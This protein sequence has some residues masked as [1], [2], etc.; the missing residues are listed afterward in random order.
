[1]R[2]EDFPSGWTEAGDEGDRTRCE[3]V[4]EA[5][6]A[7]TARVTSPRFR[8]GENTDV[9]N[10]IYVF[11]DEGAAEQALTQLAAEDTRACYAK[12]VTDA[13][14]AAGGLEV[15][16]AESARL[17]LDP[18]GDQ[19]EAARVTV[20]VSSDGVDVDVFVD[21]VFVRADRGISLGLF[22]HTVTA[23]DDELRGQLTS[24]SVRR[25]SDNLASG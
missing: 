17:S 11:A 13:L 5:K 20:P 25:L 18:L 9:Q 3:G 22:I 2:L 12:G 1:M 4:E 24:T 21:L 8:E 16:D 14:K 15:G 6:R 10:T 19:R 7:T 23:F